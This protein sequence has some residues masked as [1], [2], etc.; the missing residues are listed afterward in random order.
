MK[1]VVSSWR[2]DG[3]RVCDVYVRLPQP[4]KYFFKKKVKFMGHGNQL[5]RCWFIQREFTS[6]T[7]ATISINVTEIHTSSTSQ[8]LFAL[9]SN[10]GRSMCGT[11]YYAGK[12][13]RNVRNGCPTMT[14]VKL[15]DGKKK[16]EFMRIFSGISFVR[17]LTQNEL[18]TSSSSRERN[19]KNWPRDWDRNGIIIVII[20]MN[21]RFFYYYIVWSSYQVRSV[22]LLDLT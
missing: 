14:S 10:D 1:K 18:S 13:R 5:P 7:M 21:P 15:I 22:P 2:D 12:K 20:K 19:L 11:V 17:Q 9:G 8:N 16:T 4:H 3:L 6:F